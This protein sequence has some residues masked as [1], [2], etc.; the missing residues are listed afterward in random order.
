MN[1]NTAK[2][3]AFDQDQERFNQ[4]DGAEAD[5][6]RIFGEQANEYTISPFRQ[7]V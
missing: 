6:D 3:Q 5:V 2:L 7:N 4:N 1:T